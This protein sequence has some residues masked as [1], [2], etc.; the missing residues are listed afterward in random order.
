[1]Y[2]HINKIKFIP[3]FI[4]LWI[5]WQIVIYWNVINISDV[6][7]YL[8][9]IKAEEFDNKKVLHQIDSDLC[10]RSV[11]ICFLVVPSPFSSPHCHTDRQTDASF[12]NCQFWRMTFLLSWCYFRFTYSDILWVLDKFKF[13]IL[14]NLAHYIVPFCKCRTSI[15]IHWWRLMLFSILLTFC[16][17]SAKCNLLLDF[18]L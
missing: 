16:H 15:F 2:I 5:L 9:L 18:C 7:M 10:Y 6:V 12:V 17:Q 4:N 13:A 3:V 14:K 1:M 8:N 11:W